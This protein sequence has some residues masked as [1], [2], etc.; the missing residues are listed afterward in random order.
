MWCQK[1][2]RCVR[3]SDEEECSIHARIASRRHFVNSTA[4]KAIFRS[5]RKQE[6]QDVSRESEPSSC[7]GL[8]FGAPLN[9]RT[10]FNN[11]PAFA[12]PWCTAASTRPTKERS[13]FRFEDGVE[14]F[15]GLEHFPGSREPGWHDE[16]CPCTERPRRAVSMGQ[17][18][19]TRKQVAKLALRVPDAP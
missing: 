17:P 12:R 1:S 16:T 11:I 15:G 19:H 8:S 14:L 2:T 3:R 9:R 18:N 6:N 7:A 5:R 10:W 13:G 4:R